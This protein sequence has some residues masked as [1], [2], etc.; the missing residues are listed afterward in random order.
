MQ[1]HDN[2]GV[3]YRKL[4]TVVTVREGAERGEH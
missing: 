1:I 2:Q 3:K 4:T